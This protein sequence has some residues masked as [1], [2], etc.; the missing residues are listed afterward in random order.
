MVEVALYKTYATFQLIVYPIKCRASAVT[1]IL[2]QVTNAI[3]G[4]TF[5]DLS[6]SFCMSPES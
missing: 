1:F 2:V 5:N 6:I 4:E 3:C